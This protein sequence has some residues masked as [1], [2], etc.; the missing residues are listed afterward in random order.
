[1]YDLEDRTLRLAVEIRNFTHLLPNTVVNVEDIKQ[2]IRS[3]G[4]V[5]ANYIEANE[6]LSKKDFVLKM[7]ISRKESKETI[8]WLNIISRASHLD[9]TTLT[10]CNMLIQETSEIKKILSAIINKSI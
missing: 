10:K 8:Y 9:D 3:S 1:M 5:G 6:S 7:K 2:L 4:S